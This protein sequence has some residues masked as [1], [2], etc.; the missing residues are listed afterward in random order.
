MSSNPSA[1]KAAIK[2]QLILKTARELFCQKGYSAVTM[3]DIVE[4]CG[5]SRGGL[6]L[7]YPSTH[8]IFLEVL[9][10][11]NSGS[12]D[13]YISAVMDGTPAT[14][15]IGFFLKEQKKQILQEADSLS[16]ATYE[17]F[18]D[19]PM[20]AQENDLRKSFD[21]SVKILAKLIEKG[22]EDGDLY[23]IDPVAAARN[24]MFV[25][26]G[27]KLGTLTMDIDQKLVNQQLMYIVDSIMVAS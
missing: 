9:A 20:P 25:L 18:F 2:K 23:D 1:N 26:E 12:N 27:L 5:I 3:K 13:V 19:H 15:I 16:R 11:E 4:A 8:D 22:V 10:A 7:Y 6:Y 17:F 21:E 14:K 24:I